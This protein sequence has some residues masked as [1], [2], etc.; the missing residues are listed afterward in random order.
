LKEASTLLGIVLS[1]PLSTREEYE[2]AGA[3]FMEWLSQIR[4]RGAFSAVMPAFELLCS[5]CFKDTTKNIGTLP[6]QWLDV[7]SPSIT[8][9]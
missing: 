7:D 2:S 3:L 1:S 8:L 6:P 9:I 5:E 4:H